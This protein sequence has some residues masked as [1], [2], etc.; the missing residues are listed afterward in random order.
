MDILIDDDTDFEAGAMAGPFDLAVAEGLKW[1]REH[2]SKGWDGLQAEAAHE[3]DLIGLAYTSGV[4]GIP[5]L[6]RRVWTDS[7]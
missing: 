6:A 5:R 7:D 2:G 4:S 1:D 3:D